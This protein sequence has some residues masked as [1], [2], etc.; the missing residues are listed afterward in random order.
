MDIE[1]LEKKYPQAFKKLHKSVVKGIQASQ[2]SDT[3]LG[4]WLI[5]N[6]AAD[7]EIDSDES[8]IL[9]EVI[10]RLQKEP[11]DEAVPREQYDRVVGLLYEAYQR[12][13]W[14]T[15]GLKARE[16]D[17]HK[18]VEEILKDEKE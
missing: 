18:E 10:E 15:P 17:W 11:S 8:A 1:Y 3:E 13:I 9:C 4:D 7:C 2:L 14:N 5:E 16:E 12:N 6:I